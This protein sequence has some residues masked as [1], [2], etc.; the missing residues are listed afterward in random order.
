MG[1]DMPVSQQS[2]RPLKAI[3]LVNVMAGA[4][5]SRSVAEVSERLRAA[6]AKHGISAEMH[7]VGGGELAGWAKSAAEKVAKGEAD[8]VI[9]GGGDGTVRTIA[10]A[11]IGSGIPLGILPF[12]TLNHFARDLGI[13]IYLSQAVETISTA[14]VRTVDAGCVNG[15]VFVNNASIGA[16]PYLVLDRER[17]RKSGLKKGAAMLFAGFKL[18]RFF[19]L[20]R[21]RLRVEGQSEIFRTPCL[22]VGNNKYR[23]EFFSL[24]RRERLDGGELWIYVAKQQT[25]LSLLWFTFRALVGLTQAERDLRIFAVKSAEIDSRRRRLNIAM[26][27]EVEWL[28]PPLKFRIRPASLRVYA[29]ERE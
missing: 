1:V 23:L 25:R 22:F 21:L 5:R 29:P 9:A 6:F 19:P 20:R 17:R 28:R 14:R 10:A 8:A 18:L 13:P 4:I 24:G 26:D 16:Y 3:A 12:G 7:L 2:A 15:R 11:L 27:G